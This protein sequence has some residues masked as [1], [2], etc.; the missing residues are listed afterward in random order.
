MSGWQNDVPPK[1]NTLIDSLIPNLDDVLGVRDS[2]G[3]KLRDVFILTRSWSGKNIGEGVFTD[4][5]EQIK[6]TPYIVDYSQSIALRDGGAIRSGDLIIKG[7]SKHKYPTMDKID[8]RVDQSGLNV[9]KYYFINNMEYAV[10]QVK[11]DYVTWDI[12]VRK[13]SDETN[14][15]SP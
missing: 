8:C 1:G 9:Q 4:K 3:A 13:L 6:P 14:K 2:I 10:I 7:I 12:H 15:V 11:D 5:T